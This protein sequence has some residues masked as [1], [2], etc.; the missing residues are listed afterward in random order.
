V[1]FF[2]EHKNYIRET[3]VMGGMII[4]SVTVRRR[5]IVESDALLEYDSGPLWVVDEDFKR[6]KELNFVLYDDLSSLYTLYLDAEASHVDDIEDSLTAGAE[7]VT[8]SERT[9]RKKIRDILSLTEAVIFYLREDEGKAHY[10][11]QNGGFYIF[12]DMD[13]IK[14]VRI[15]FTGKFECENCYKIVPIG[16][17]N[18]GRDKETSALPQEKHREI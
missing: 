9:D 12:S 4:P 7:M 2:A 11:L 14:G 18:A 16:E 5:K 6:G 10:F 1:I 17:M 3:V 15:Q 13:I 8:I